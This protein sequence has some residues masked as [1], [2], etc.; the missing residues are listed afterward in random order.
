MIILCYQH[1]QT[2][3]AQ[4]LYFGMMFWILS[5]SFEEVFVV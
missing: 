3:Q 4:L 5:K 1:I 2:I